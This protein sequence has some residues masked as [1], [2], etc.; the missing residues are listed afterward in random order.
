MCIY[1]Y[2]INIEQTDAYILF[3]K[4]FHALYTDSNWIDNINMKSIQ[5]M[6]KERNEFIAFDTHSFI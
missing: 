5:G 3:I 1:I 2:I 6:L 4:L